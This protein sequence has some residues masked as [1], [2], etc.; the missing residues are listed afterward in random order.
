MLLI[1]TQ[2]KDG[3]FHATINQRYISPFRIIKAIFLKSQQVK[4]VKVHDLGIK[5]LDHYNKKRQSGTGGSEDLAK[6]FSAGGGSWEAALGD[7]R[8]PV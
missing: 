1:I 4:L 7:R 6:F 8:R 5:H 3:F 2:I